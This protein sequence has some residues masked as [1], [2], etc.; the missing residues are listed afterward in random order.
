MPFANFLLRP[1]ASSAADDNT[2]VSCVI[3]PRR[4]RLRLD[5]CSDKSAILGQ[6]WAATLCIT[7]INFPNKIIMISEYEERK[8]FGCEGVGKH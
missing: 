7:M 5:I 3:R 2:L 6:K 1:V 8:L 4:T